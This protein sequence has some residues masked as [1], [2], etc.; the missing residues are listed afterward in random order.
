MTIAR[1]CRD[2]V[3]S[4]NCVAAFATGSD[5]DL[6]T[7]CARCVGMCRRFL[8]AVQ[9]DVRA[10]LL[11]YKDW[12]AQHPSPTA[13]G[14]APSGTLLAASQPQHT[15]T[16][17]RPFST[18]QPTAAAAVNK[19]K[20]KSSQ[21][22]STRGPPVQD[23]ENALVWEQQGTAGQ[24]NSWQGMQGVTGFNTQQQQQQY[25]PRGLAADAQQAVYATSSALPAALS[26]MHMR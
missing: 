10:Y 3:S 17:R 9:H 15:P 13:A 24:G 23:K 12:A 14:T 7:H 4:I 21:A 18:I 25:I 11:A 20:A 5:A 22:H 19:G 8:P 2:I 26:P 6:L 16:H 1:P